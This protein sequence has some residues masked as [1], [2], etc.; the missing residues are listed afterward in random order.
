MTGVSTLAPCSI[1]ALAAIIAG[2]VLGVRYLEQ[3]SLKGA[4]QAAIGRARAPEPGE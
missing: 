3:G 4:F 1:L 2:G